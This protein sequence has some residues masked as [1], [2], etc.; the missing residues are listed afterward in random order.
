MNSE[1]KKIKIIDFGIAGAISSMRWE[2]IDTGSLSYM[3]PECFSPKKNFRFDGK[4]DIWTIGVILYAMV[5]G[6]LPFKG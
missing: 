4:I 6:E 5:C 3:A 1:E 2:Q